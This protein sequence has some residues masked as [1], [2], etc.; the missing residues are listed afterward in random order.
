M[1]TA[2]WPP[3]VARANPPRRDQRGSNEQRESP[4]SPA[5]TL[6]CQ[7]RGRHRPAPP[8]RALGPHPL[9]LPQQVP[10][11]IPRPGSARSGGCA[12]RALGCVD[13]QLGLPQGAAGAQPIGLRRCSRCISPKT[14]RPP[15]R[16][17]A[18][19]RA[20]WQFTLRWALLSTLQCLN[21]SPQEPYHLCTQ[22]RTLRHRQGTL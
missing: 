6:S 4:M 21:S 20:S 19:A 3:A 9:Q 11:C 8:G 13:S 18:A 1:V 16:R 12:G 14:W 7:V 17:R 5:M 10:P 2:L 22:K 15:E